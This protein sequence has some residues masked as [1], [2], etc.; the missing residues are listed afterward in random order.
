MTGIFMTKPGPGVSQ[1]NAEFADKIRGVVFDLD[2]TVY[3]GENVVDGVIDVI[4]ILRRNGYAIYFCTNNSTRTR[5]DI[6]DKLINLGITATKESIY[7]AAFAAAWYLS[8]SG[9]QSVSVLGTVGLQEELSEAGLVV[10]NDLDQ[11]Q[12]LVIGL[13]L[14][15]DYKKMASFSRLLDKNLP[16]I[17]CNR[18]RWFPG[19]NGELKPGCGIM[20]ALVE[21]LLGRNVNLVVGK[22]NT[23]LLEMLSR[24]SGLKNDELLI[25][26]DS[27]ESDIVLANSF[28]SPSVFYAPHGFKEIGTVCINKMNQLPEYLECSY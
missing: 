19:N 14:L 26:G 1:A 24:Q 12:A 21:S 22:P 23:L 2:G 28:G 27:F 7:S 3:E 18:D 8:G 13:D 15:I 9:I 25:V 17:A 5:Q 16:V 11:G 20:V 10:T 4:E 6:A